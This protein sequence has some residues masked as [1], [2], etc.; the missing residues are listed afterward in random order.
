VVHKIYNP[1]LSTVKD[2]RAVRT[3][4]A[5][6]RALLEL[7]EVKPLERVS[8]RDIAA[9]SG[10]GYTTFFRHHPTKQALL[11]DVAAEQIRELVNLSMRVLDSTNLRA[12][13]VALCTYVDEHRKL[14]STLLTGGAAG[15]LREEF[16]RV[17]K[18]IS[19]QRA[20]PDSL[21]PAEVATNLVVSG[22]IELLSWWLRQ[23][24]PLPIEQIAEFHDRVVV[25]P[26]VQAHG[27]GRPSKNRLKVS[28][29]TKSDHHADTEKSARHKRARPRS[30]RRD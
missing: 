23:A 8:I 17:A 25:S 11:D 1:H 4:E 2:A 6:R 7:L 10:V 29:T 5:L 24:D 18:E 16:L 15:A 12:A 9:K 22:T 20:R 21:L 26:A 19:V 3:R 13:S 14:W 27:T 28:S 30:R